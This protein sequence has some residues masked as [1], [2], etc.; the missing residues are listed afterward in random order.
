MVTTLVSHRSAQAELNI[1]PVLLFR[2]KKIEGGVLLQHQPRRLDK[3]PASSA[4]DASYALC[5]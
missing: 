2:P 3:R 5:N 4:R 1:D